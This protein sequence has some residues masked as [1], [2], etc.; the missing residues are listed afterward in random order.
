[1]PLLAEQPQ[2]MAREQVLLAQ[3][4][5]QPWFQGDRWTPVDGGL[6]FAFTLHLLDKVFEAVLVYPRLFPD[7]PCYVRPRRK[8]EIWSTHQYVSGTLCL[9]RGPDNWHRSV[10]G[11]DMVHSA[12][13]LLGTERLARRSRAIQP[14]RSRHIETT[15]QRMRFKTC[16]LILTQGCFDAIQTANWGAE[17]KLRVELALSY[18]DAHT[19]LV[20]LGVGEPSVS[21]HDVPSDVLRTE[22]YPCTGWVVAHK[23]ATST[24]EFRSAQELRNALAEAWPWTEELGDMPEAV[25]VLGGGGELRGFLLNGGDHPTFRELAVVDAREVDGQRQPTHLSGI[26]GKTVAI[27][28][29]GSVG[30]KVAVS[31]CRAGARH[32]VLVDDDTLGPENLVRN[33]LTWRDVG[34]DKVEAL[35]R[36]IELIAAD[37]K[38]EVFRTHLAGQE[39][40]QVEARLAKRLIEVDLV[41]DATA[42]ASAFL[43]AAALC[44]RAGI[45][46]IWGEVFAGGGGGL[47]ARS[48]PGQDADPLAIRA[49]IAGVLGT[50]PD[51]PKVATSRRYEGELDGEILVASDADVSALAAAMSQLTLDTLS[52]ANPSDY[53]HAAYL[54]GFRKFWVFEQPFDTR[55]IDCSG[56]SAT[57]DE[58]STLTPQEEDAL[59]L[60]QKQLGN[61]DAASDRTL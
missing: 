15:G 8:G 28:G 34:F 38:V 42:A 39:N 59:Q 46:M 36:Q 1:M 55:P 50:L 17:G 41:V 27:L 44:R 45:A 56:V 26:G 53:P 25:F 57:P 30:S 49:H 13:M 16:R 32:F 47:I 21:V 12:M 31:L 19:V 2:R 23:A 40:P 37:V 20:P 6:E 22:S 14:V 54:L 4:A 33:E 7:V 24:T 61:E 52:Q 35:K 60:L 10:T 43:A 3:L 48:R 11:A 58:L 18:L 29:A 9:E 5:V 51:V